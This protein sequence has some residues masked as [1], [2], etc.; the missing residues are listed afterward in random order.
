MLWAHSAFFN[1]F[2][3]PLP[4]APPFQYGTGLRRD[5]GGIAVFSRVVDVR[6]I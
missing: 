1:S 4:L 2:E 3:D 6:G 5:G